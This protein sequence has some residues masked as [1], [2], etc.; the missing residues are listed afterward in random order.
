M[1]REQKVGFYVHAKNRMSN[2]KGAA[3]YIGR[4]VSRPAIAESRI[5]SKWFIFGM[6]SIRTA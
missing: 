6:S 2:A 5:E 4:Y 1:Y 3:K